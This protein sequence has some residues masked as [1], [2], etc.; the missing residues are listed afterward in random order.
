MQ[1]THII[2]FQLAEKI[3]AFHHIATQQNIYYSGQKYKML[4]NF[5]RG[6]H[7]KKNKKTFD[8]S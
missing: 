1:F 7:N 3:I 4:S 8:P 6:G 5:Q 2:H